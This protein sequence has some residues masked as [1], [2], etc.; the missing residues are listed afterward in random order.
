MNIFLCSTQFVSCRKASTSVRLGAAATLTGRSFALPSLLA[1]RLASFG[2]VL[3]R[4]LQILNRRIPFVTAQISTIAFIRRPVE[5]RDSSA[6]FQVQWYGSE[7]AFTAFVRGPLREDE[8][9]MF[10]KTFI[11][12]GVPV[13]TEGR[14]IICKEYSSKVASFYSLYSVR[15][16]MSGVVKTWNISE[17]CF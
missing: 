15:H 3:G 5:A 10:R 13:G 4:T 6:G 16:D 11:D 7:E 17:V 14:R 8:R 1:T 12:A 2:S 9:C